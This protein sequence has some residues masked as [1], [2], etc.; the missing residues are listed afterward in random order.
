MLNNDMVIEVK[1]RRGVDNTGKSKMW[2][3]GLSVA[4]HQHE[5][6]VAR[7][8]LIRGDTPMHIG[9]EWAVAI[10]VSAADCSG[11]HLENIWWPAYEFWVLDNE[12]WTTNT[13]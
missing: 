10:Q 3:A 8:G 6:T 7:I 5:C 9:A 11:K 2:K 13:V 4:N 1:C 12:F